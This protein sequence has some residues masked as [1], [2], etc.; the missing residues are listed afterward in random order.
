M[1]H[2]RVRSQLLPGLPQVNISS[3]IRAFRREPQRVSCSAHSELPFRLQLS[4]AGARLGEEKQFRSVSSLAQFAPRWTHAEAAQP[5]DVAGGG[6]LCATL[7]TAGCEHPEGAVESPEGCVRV[8]PSSG[9]RNPKDLEQL[10]AWH[11]QPHC[12]EWG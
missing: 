7:G 11:S 8:M 4:R 3:R 2:V 6:M 9:G 1:L 10:A 5:P 12:L